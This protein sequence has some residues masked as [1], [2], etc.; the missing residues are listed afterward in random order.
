[1]REK[2]ASQVRDRH[3]SGHDVLVPTQQKGWASAPRSGDTKKSKLKDEKRAQTL[4][5]QVHTWQL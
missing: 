3:D 4:F 2:W 1:M 5:A